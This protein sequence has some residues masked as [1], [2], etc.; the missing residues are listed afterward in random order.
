[1][2]NNL[3]YAEMVKVT[4]VHVYIYVR[5]KAHSIIHFVILVKKNVI[6]NHKISLN[7][8]NLEILFDQYEH[9]FH[10]YINDIEESHFKSKFK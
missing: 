3:I 7:K 1:M 2:K 9:D 5:V 10:I 4:I 6:Y 8:L